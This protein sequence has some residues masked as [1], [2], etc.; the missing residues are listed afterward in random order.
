MR[1][2]VIILVGLCIV[3]F[4]CYLKKN[5]KRLY[6]KYR[7]LKRKNSRKYH[8][9]KRKYF[10]QLNDGKRCL[11][12]VVEVMALMTL[13][14]VVFR[15]TGIIEYN[16]EERRL[17]LALSE[18]NEKIEKE[19][20][21]Y[22]WAQISA[23]LIVST[24]VSLLS[25]FSATYVYGKKQINVI[26]NN[27]SIFSLGKMYV[28]L[29]ALN[30]GSLMICIKEKY[31]CIILG[32]FIIML[33]VVSY[34][35][36]KIIF[37]YTHPNFYQDCTKS[38]YI[39]RERRHIK[40]AMPMA[41]YKDVEIEKLKIKTL[42]LIQKNNNDYNVNINVLMD[43]MEISLM[44]N[45]KNTQEY[46]TE[47]IYDR[48]DF[49]SSIL[50]III[51]LINYDRESEACNL[52]AILCS[53]LVYYRII[54]IQDYFS[55]SII[56]DLINA[57]KYIENERKALEH[58][59]KLWSIIENDIFLVY[60][61]NCELDFSYCRLAKDDL[62]YYITH[63]DYLDKVYLSVR[64]N[65]KLT[66]AEK[67]RIYNQLYDDI[68]M[69]ELKEK[70][71]KRDIR[72][73]WN[74]DLNTNTISIPLIIK[75]E[76]LVLM[77]M[78][79]FEE[80][81]IENLKRFK[82]MN[83]SHLLMKYITCVI[84]ASIIRFMNGDCKREFLYDIRLSEEEIINT[85]TKVRFHDKKEFGENELKE[86]YV[87]LKEEYITSSPKRPYS[88][89]P[90]IRTSLDCLNN[91]FYF[92]FSKVGKEDMFIELVGDDFEENKKILEIINKLE[93]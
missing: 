14:V 37:F 50:E 80:Q 51:H 81:D 67:E 5:Y 38:D 60:L 57:G 73:L 62:I 72:H 88:I 19:S 74:D 58:Y 53:R 18:V 40:K 83:L 56:L 42:E 92:L 87:L 77:F 86:L 21:G 27:K 45:S 79:M 85:Y 12:F 35:L 76:P 30:F 61:Y 1:A 48:T 75:G 70:H 31:Y 16:Q 15:A 36:F 13:L 47:M 32:N 65:S 55:F 24:I 69:M 78:R 84:T 10:T 11:L 3:W 6:G 17:F 25:V 93:I 59:R 90:N 43:M 41:T 26:Y 7:Y 49:V 9:F 52:M 91:Y 82:T 28:F 23:S 64:E 89:Y 68:R 29:M 22:L 34:M 63:S 33:C 66:H 39:K 4:I 44:N 54:L 20:Y 46:Y 71:P 8:I 2:F